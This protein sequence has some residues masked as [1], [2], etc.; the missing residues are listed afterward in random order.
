VTATGHRMA[1]APPDIAAST[2]ERS[3]A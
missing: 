2:I 3:V 1:L